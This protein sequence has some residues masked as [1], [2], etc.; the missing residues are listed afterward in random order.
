MLSK[1]EIAA[2]IAASVAKKGPKPVAIDNTE[3]VSEFRGL[4]GSVFHVPAGR[5]RK[6]GVTFAYIA[7]NNRMEVSTALQHTNDAFARKVGTKTAI[8]HFRE[9]KTVHLPLNGDRRNALH[10]LRSI[11]I[12]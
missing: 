7:R 2:R 8:E 11:V 9:G 6:K 10:V 5:F 3:L 1:E 4:G 12:G